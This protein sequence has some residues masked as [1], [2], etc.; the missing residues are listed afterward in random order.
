MDTDDGTVTW[1]RQIGSS[2]K[3]VRILEMNAY[4]CFAEF[5]YSQCLFIFH[6]RQNMARNNGVFADMEGDCLL[7]GDTTGELYRSRHDKSTATDV[8]FVKL[9]QEN[10]AFSSTTEMVRRK[11]TGAGIGVLVLLSCF[12]FSFYR[13]WGHYRSMRWQRAYKKDDDFNGGDAVFRDN[14]STSNGSNRNFS[15]GYSDEPENGTMEMHTVPAS[16]SYRDEAAM[17][18]GKSVV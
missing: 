15:S 5:H 11:H 3:E 6:L 7:Y 10:G 12:A 13:F 4:R 1:M 17:R 16:G 9:A 14:P 2:G 18:P 8:F